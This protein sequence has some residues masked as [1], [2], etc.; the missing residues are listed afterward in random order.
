MVTPWNMPRGRS[1]SHSVVSAVSRK[2]RHSP[3]WGGVK[4]IANGFKYGNRSAVTAIHF[5]D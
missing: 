5:M 4:A 1:A 2:N 3:Q